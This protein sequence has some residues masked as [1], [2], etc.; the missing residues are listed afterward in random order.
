MLSGT[1]RM[2]MYFLMSVYTQ[3]VNPDVKT[4]TWFLSN[5]VQNHIGVMK[6]NNG[7]TILQLFPANMKVNLWQLYKRLNRDDYM[8]YDKKISGGSSHYFFFHSW[9]SDPCRAKYW[10]VP[11]KKLWVPLVHSLF[12]AFIVD[13]PWGIATHSMIHLLRLF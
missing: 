11:K 3:H 1:V 12:F 10:W 6:T 5:R 8:K 4:I 9:K 2:A 7:K 13:N